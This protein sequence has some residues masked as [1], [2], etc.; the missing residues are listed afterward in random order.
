MDNTCLCIQ[1]PP[2]SGK[3]FT[4][5]HVIST[6]VKQG[7]RIGIMSN[8]HAAI[9]H[10]LTSVI[11]ELPDSNIAKVGGFKTQTAFKE[12]YPEEQYPNFYYRG[13]MS[14]TQ[15]KPYEYFSVIGATAYA[16]VKEIVHEDPLD[17]LFVDEASQVALANLIA[18][19]GVAKNIVLMLMGDQMQLEQPIQGSHPDNAGSS[20]LEFMLKDHAVI[21]EDKGI[22]LERTYRMHPAVCQPLSEVVYEGK[23][24]ADKANQNQA[25]HIENPNYITQQNGIL[26]ILVQNPIQGLPRPFK[27]P[28]NKSRHINTT[29]G[30]WFLFQLFTVLVVT[31]S[32]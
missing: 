23:L 21:P 18:I 10:L 30:S 12:V 19:S 9:L 13:G 26:P 32:I 1:G 4:A 22:F 29:F 8:S 24:T 20:T 3:S 11:K 28:A 15:S 16:F 5:K 27:L 7:K 31:S 6:V 17:Y 2:G 25:I 14:F